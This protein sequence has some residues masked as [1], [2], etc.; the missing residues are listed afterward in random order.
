MDFCE[1]DNHFAVDREYH[2]PKRSIGFFSRQ[3]PS[4]MFSLQL[5]GAVIY[6]CRAGS[7]CTDAQWVHASAWIARALE[8]VGCRVHVEGLNHLDSVTGPCVIASNHMSTLETFLLPGII[9]PRRPL[10]FVIKKSLLEVPGFG[11]GMRTRNPVSLGRTNPREDL[12]VTLEEGIDRLRRGLSLVIFPEG[13][14]RKQFQPEHFNSIAVKLAR[15]AGV[16]V[17][18]LALKTDAWSQGSLLKDFGGIHPELPIHFRF[19]E[20]LTIQGNGRAEQMA[21]CT[22]IEKAT[23]EWQCEEQE[24]VQGGRL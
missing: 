16:P 20:P 7:S 14:R 4:L 3:F 8:S 21:L 9:R 10:T 2:T 18:P 23:R 13:T 24:N 17:L 12:A 1:F 22:F 19:G 15:R 11:K 5:G 6:F